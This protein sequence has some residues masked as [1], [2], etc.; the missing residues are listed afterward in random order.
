MS[1]KPEVSAVKKTEAVK[2]SVASIFAAFEAAEAKKK[3][4]EIASEEPEVT[5]AKPVVVKSAVSSIFEA[6]E[7]NVTSKEKIEDKKPQDTDES[8]MKI[9]KVFDFAG[10]AVT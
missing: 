6:A 7:K 1:S 2:S 10:E 9:T 4:P 8:K 5:T 3:L